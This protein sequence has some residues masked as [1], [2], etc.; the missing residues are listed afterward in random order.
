MIFKRIDFIV[1]EQQKSSMSPNLEHKMI[2]GYTGTL[3][4]L[5]S[6]STLISQSL[7]DLFSTLFCF[8]L[9]F[10]AVKHRFNSQLP[11]IFKKVGLIEWIFIP[12]VL[13]IIIGFA[14]N[15]HPI[16]L[17]EKYFW[18]TRTLEFRWIL[19]LYLLIAGFR[20]IDFQKSKLKWFNMAALVCSIYGLI[21]YFHRLSHNE[22]HIVRLEGLFHFYMTHAHVYGP[23]LCVLLGLFFW[24]YKSLTPQQF[25]LYLATLITMSSSVILTMTRGIW[26]GLFVSIMI[27]GFLWKPKKG[28]LISLIIILGSVILYSSITSIKTR[29]DSTFLVFKNNVTRAETNDTERVTLWKTNYLI[30]RD[31]PIF[32]AGYGHNVFLL[33]EYYDKQGLPKDQFEG[34]AHN[35]YM[36]FLSGTGILGFI[37]YIFFLGSILWLSFRAYKNI[38]ET[39]TWHKGLALGT[40]SGQLCFIFGGLTEA[41]FEHSKVRHTMLI[42]WALGLWLYQSYGNKTMNS[43][44]VLPNTSLKE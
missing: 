28:I 8:Y 31:H 24:I 19:V 40:I 3:L 7:M 16:S 23:Y 35:Q 39:D 22:N 29:V 18:L 9:F 4:V 27:A 34:H 36:H 33:R 41:N 10:I 2:I 42:I 37:C 32:G 30:F 14:I 5:Y 43:S 21:E 17:K 25:W 44:Q 38:S 15:P 6:I 11:L 20:I 26:I 13:V 1:I 12:W